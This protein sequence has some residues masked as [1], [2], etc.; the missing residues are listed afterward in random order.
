MSTHVSE[1]AAPGCSSKEARERIRDFADCPQRARNRRLRRSGPSRGGRSSPPGASPSSRRASPP[2]TGE[3]EAP[4]H[5]R[6]TRRRRR[7]AADDVCF[8]PTPSLAASTTSGHGGPP[9]PLDRPR[10][11]LRVFLSRD[12]PGVGA[13]PMSEV[14]VSASPACREN[15][16]AS[17]WRHV[18][19]TSGS[20]A[21]ESGGPSTT[22]MCGFRAPGVPAV[23]RRLGEARRRACDARATE[24]LFEPSA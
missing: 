1:A 15:G 6:A 5:R 22:S 4:A 24:P 8:P 9:F 12:D 3:R 11:P 21:A 19:T 2:T 17:R 16:D 20:A 14:V 23:S 7:R 18:V 10:P 13:K